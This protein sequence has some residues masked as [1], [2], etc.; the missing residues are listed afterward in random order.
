MLFAPNPLSNIET[1]IIGRETPVHKVA[2]VDDHESSPRVNTNGEEGMSPRKGG[3][4]VTTALYRSE[5][6]A[7]EA[8]DVSRDNSVSCLV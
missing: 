4:K 8:D 6:S 3:I 2:S 7:G 5:D 1:T